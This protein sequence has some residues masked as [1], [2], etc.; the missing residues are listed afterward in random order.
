MDEIEY[1]KLIVSNIATI[2][3][4]IEKNDKLSPIDISTLR[5]INPELFEVLKEINFD[6]IYE[7]LEKNRDDLIYSPKINRLLTQQ[8][9]DG[10]RSLLSYIYECGE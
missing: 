10:L 3:A 8:G 1:E 6:E 4:I 5:T 7:I 2:A 9:K